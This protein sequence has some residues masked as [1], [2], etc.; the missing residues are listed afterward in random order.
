MRRELPELPADSFPFGSVDDRLLVGAGRSGGIYLEADGQYEFVSAGELVASSGGFILART[1]DAVLNCNLSRIELA[2]G[3][4][5]PHEPPPDFSFSALWWIDEPV[6][7]QVDAALGLS[8]DL[9]PAIWD[10]LTGEL[11]PLAIGQGRGATWSPDGSWVFVSSADKVTAFHRETLTKV[12]V[13]VPEGVG[14]TAALQLA[15][16]PVT[17][18]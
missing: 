12:S 11:T 14:F 16:L 3:I 5:T 18:G 2:T 7:P 4:S 13:P 8:S 10:L 9:G 6:S 15:I 1:Y 17:P